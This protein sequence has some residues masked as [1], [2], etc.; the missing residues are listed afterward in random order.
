[1]SDLDCI[2]A[3]DANAVVKSCCFVPGL[4][5]FVALDAIIEVP[6]R[7]PV[8][9]LEERRMV[10]VHWR[11]VR[12]HEQLHLKKW[13]QPDGLR[14]AGLELL[15]ALRVELFVAIVEVPRALEDSVTG[16][17][18]WVCT[19]TNVSLTSVGESDPR[20]AEAAWVLV[21]NCE[22][23][24][25]LEDPDAISLISDLVLK[26]G[27]P[28]EVLDHMVVSSAALASGC[29]VCSSAS[30]IGMRAKSDADL[31]SA[32]VRADFVVPTVGVRLPVLRVVVT[33]F[34]DAV[35]AEIVSAA[36]V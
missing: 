35:E 20:C 36:S 21:D 30:V 3:A 6:Q 2:G 19:A 8:L 4:G 24:W 11:R 14:G 5:V 1:M 34:V 7:E 23:S 22:M 27:R 33:H 9:T 10:A 26:G 31:A 29:L 12:R 15:D 18:G 17:V 16:S 25:L 28:A 13:G 32:L